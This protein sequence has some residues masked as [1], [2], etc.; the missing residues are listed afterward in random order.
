MCVSNLM[1]IKMA[2]EHV[3]VLDVI[4]GVEFDASTSSTQDVSNSEYEDVF[5]DI[6]F[7]CSSDLS[8]LSNE[9]QDSIKPI[10]V[11]ARKHLV[12]GKHIEIINGQQKKYK[13]TICKCQFSWKQQIR[14]HDY[15]VT[16]KRPLKCELCD[17]RFVKKSH[18]VYHTRTHSGESPYQCSI[19]LKKFKQL[20]KLKRHEKIHKEPGE[21]YKFQCS[22]C[23]KNYSNQDSLKKHE[24]KHESKT[25][26][27][28]NCKK[29]YLDNFTFKQHL[30]THEVPKFICEVC[31]RR[32]RMKNSL[33][34]HLQMHEDHYPHQ[35]S[36]CRKTFRTRKELNQ[37]KVVHDTS[38][39][40]FDCS[41]C[42]V[43]CGRKDNLLRHVR[44]CHLDPCAK[45][46]QMTKKIT[47]HSQDSD[48]TE[49]Q[50]SMDLNGGDSVKE[51][52]EGTANE[53]SSLAGEFSQTSSEQN[54]D[55]TTKIGLVNKG[56]NGKKKTRSAVHKR[57]SSKQKG[58]K[59]ESRELKRI[60]TV[61]T[62]TIATPGLNNAVEKVLVED[63]PENLRGDKTSVLITPSSIAE[64]PVDL[65][66]NESLI[67]ERSQ[68]NELSFASAKRSVIV[69]TSSF[70]KPLL[71]E[72]NLQREPVI[73]F[74]RIPPE[75]KSLAPDPT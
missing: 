40:G 68:N 36:E 66:K 34:I 10:E 55:C 21:G 13:C 1:F 74:F 57:L 69:H 32:F 56:S 37:H 62:E 22:V 28:K 6:D 52:S 60:G 15:C 30:A 27:C 8:S 12:I 7:D 38:N 41:L 65:S 42:S 71:H 50:N 14:Y 46:D 3:N 43:M 23:K 39:P 18:L 51:S 70:H 5:K 73:K 11:Q 17:K 72:A 29:K 44:N 58:K 49:V 33:N 26:Q 19:C 31:G 54:T 47:E 25:Y 61:C 45:K 64:V 20:C 2:N 63:K 59:K 9:E 24:L 67:T 53:P 4:Y 16:G 48:K 75:P 35:C